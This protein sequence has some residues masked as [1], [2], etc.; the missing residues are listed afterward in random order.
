MS[1]VVMSKNRCRTTY[2]STTYDIRH[3]GYAMIKVLVV[4]DSLFMRTLVSDLL[5]ADPEIEVNAGALNTVGYMLLKEGRTDDAITV[6]AY[7]VKAFPEMGAL[8]DSLAEGYAVKGDREN[9]V[10]NYKLAI[11]SDPDNVNAIEILR[12]LEN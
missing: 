1:Y 8:L 6:F 2:D 5:D 7:N 3:T 10:A 9:A 11:E 4:D 12:H